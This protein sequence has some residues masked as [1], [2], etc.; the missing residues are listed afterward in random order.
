MQLHANSRSSH[1]SL[2]ICFSHALPNDCPWTKAQLWLGWGWECGFLKGIQGWALPGHVCFCF[3]SFREAHWVL[4]KLHIQ[5]FLP[6]FFPPQLQS[7]GA[8]A[9]VLR[10]R[11]WLCLHT[12]LSRLAGSRV[13]SGLIL[14]HCET[15]DL[16]TNFRSQDQWSG[17]VCL[18]CATNCCFI[19]CTGSLVVRFRTLKKYFKPLWDRIYRASDKKKTLET[20]FGF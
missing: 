1:W 2:W 9:V 19:V 12:P 8:D 18:V 11:S 16:L 4:F 7:S 10:S 17:L 15:G 20:S 5:E 6:S 14:S 13:D 3:Y